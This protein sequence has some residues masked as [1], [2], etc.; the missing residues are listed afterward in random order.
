MTMQAGCWKRAMKLG[1]LAL[2]L[3]GLPAGCASENANVAREF[4]VDSALSALAAWLL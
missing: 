1:V 2:S 4:V 3:F